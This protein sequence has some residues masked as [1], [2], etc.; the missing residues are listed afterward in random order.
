MV[1]SQPAGT[2]AKASGSRSKSDH[3]QWLQHVHQVQSQRTPEACEAAKLRIERS[4]IHEASS[5]K[6]KAVKGHAIRSRALAAEGLKQMAK[7]SAPQESSEVQQRW[8]AAQQFSSRMQ[9]EAVSRAD[10]FRSEGVGVAQLLDNADDEAEEAMVGAAQLVGADDARDMAAV[11]AEGVG[12]QAAGGSASMADLLSQ[13]RVEPKDA[14]E[15][16]AKFGLYE[17]YA[18]EVEQ[19]RNNLVKFH[20]ETRPT[21][22]E[23]IGADMDKQI[24][25]I[26]SEEAMGIADELR[27]WFVYHMMR[28]A[29][30]NNLRMAS[31]LDGFEKKLEFLASSDQNECPVCLETFDVDAGRA[32]ETLACC[33]KVCK[34][35]WEHW[36][37]VR[38]GR[39][40]CPLCRHEDFIGAIMEAQ[41]TPPGG[42]DSE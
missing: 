32:P 25:A 4:R 35:C 27:E 36:S 16:A 39:P 8:R 15:C 31:I 40:F 41:S 42:S 17:G 14:A 10:M 33:H 19:M 6:C 9:D 12:S 23:V 34:Q 28:Q 24:R 26:D 18:S 5:R 13:L 3:V 7:C 21:V 22:P 29:E 38:S 20:G 11:G 1:F 37:A 30:R 2:M